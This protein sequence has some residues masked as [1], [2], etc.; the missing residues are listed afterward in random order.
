MLALYEVVHISIS[1]TKDIVL[2]QFVALCWISHRAV[3]AGLVCAS[4]TCSP[5]IHLDSI[6]Y[7]LVYILNIF[8]AF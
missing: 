7:A 5:G 1:L 6:R 2:L 8:L 4:S 3:A